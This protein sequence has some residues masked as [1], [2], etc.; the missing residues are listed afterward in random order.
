MTSN[1]GRWI[2]FFAAGPVVMAAAY[3]ISSLLTSGDPAGETDMAVAYELLIWVGAP[4]AFV[5]VL[6]IL[7]GLL[8]VLTKSTRE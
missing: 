3:G 2:Y 6:P 7:T 4:I 5:G 8:T 1:K